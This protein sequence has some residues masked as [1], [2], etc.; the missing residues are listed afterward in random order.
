MDVL[1]GAS[2]ISG[3]KGENLTDVLAYKC[4]RVPKG[5]TKTQE[6]RDLVTSLYGEEVKAARAAVSGAAGASSAATV[7]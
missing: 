5:C 2:E 4:V 7:V 6:K 1:A 3:L